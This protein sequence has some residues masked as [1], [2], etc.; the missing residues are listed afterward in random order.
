MKSQL[1]CCDAYTT[2]V[3]L[4]K[5]FLV[6]GLENTQKEKLS[7]TCKYYIVRLCG[8]GSELWRLIKRNPSNGRI[9]W[10]YQLG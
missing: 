3:W 6:V 2:T 1:V 8:V 5:K 4:I 7:V 10:F 9:I